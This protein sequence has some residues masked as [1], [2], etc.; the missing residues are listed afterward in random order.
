MTPRVAPQPQSKS[1]QRGPPPHLP[2]SGAATPGSK[3]CIDPDTASV[4]QQAVPHSEDKVPT[5]KVQDIQLLGGQ[6]CQRDICQPPPKAVKLHQQPFCQILKT[7]LK[8]VPLGVTRPLCGPRNL[9][10]S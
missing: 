7:Y 8:T 6:P 10:K 1:Q 5:V 4:C 9:Q 3:P 2:T